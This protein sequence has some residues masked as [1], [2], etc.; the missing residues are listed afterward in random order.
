MFRSYRFGTGKPGRRPVGGGGGGIAVWLVAMASAATLLTGPGGGRVFAQDASRGEVRALIEARQHAVLSA[1]IPGRIARLS[2][3]AGQSFKTGDLLVAFDCASYQAEL[4]GARAQLNAA[5]VTARLNRRLNSLHSTGEAEV[6]LAEAKAQVARADVR[7]AE[8]QA[9]RCDIKAPFDGR[10]VERRIQEH[11]TVAAGAPLLEILSD[12][13]LKVE[14][15]V[16]SSWLVSLKPGQR[17]D[18]HIDE[19]GATLPGEVLLPGAKVD[20]AS[21]SVKVTA[22]LTGAGS[23]FGLVP[24]MSGTALFPP[25]TVS[26][27]PARPGTVTIGPAP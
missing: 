3:E 10:V 26:S 6:Q 22:K 9:R 13:D 7:K 19:T 25:P 17:F 1:E 16:P 24:G 2:I 12:R 18:L 21:Q 27:L 14:L 5:E 4:D 8:V 20:P 23:P 15:I 11:E